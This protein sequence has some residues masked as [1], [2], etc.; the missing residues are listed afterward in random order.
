[1]KIKIVAGMLRSLIQT[2][3]ITCRKIVHYLSVIYL[4]WFGK[5]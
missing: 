5:P 3:H 2:L 4:T 1:L